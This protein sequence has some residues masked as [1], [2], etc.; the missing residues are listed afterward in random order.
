MS[1]VGHYAFYQTGQL[2]ISLEAS[3]VPIFWIHTWN[4]D[5]VTV[6]FNQAQPLTV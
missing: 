5:P 2:T 3:S 4:P 1:L 6:L